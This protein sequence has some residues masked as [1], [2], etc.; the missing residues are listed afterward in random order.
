[1]ILVYQVLTPTK[2][3]LVFLANV[4]IL[5]HLEIAHRDREDRKER[6]D[7]REEMVCC[8]FKTVVVCFQI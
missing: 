6:K 2:S 8:N 7:R 1:M 3:E 5:V 4:V